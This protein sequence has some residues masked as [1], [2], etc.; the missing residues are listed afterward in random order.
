MPY[1]GIARKIKQTPTSYDTEALVDSTGHSF[2][3]G[4]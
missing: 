2:E 4:L 1:R 3:I